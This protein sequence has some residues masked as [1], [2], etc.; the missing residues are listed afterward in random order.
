M[1]Q[2]LW[3]AAAVELAVMVGLSLFSRSLDADDILTECPQFRVVL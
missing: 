1:L 2:E 3:A